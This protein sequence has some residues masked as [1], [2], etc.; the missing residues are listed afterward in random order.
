MS[1]Y[2]QPF[3]YDVYEAFC[4]DAVVEVLDDPFSSFASHAESELGVSHEVHE[5]VGDIVH[6]GAVVYDSGFFEDVS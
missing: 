5:V 6:A 3:G 4:Y 1:G 2:P